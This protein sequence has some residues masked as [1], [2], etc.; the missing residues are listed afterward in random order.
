[1][2]HPPVTLFVCRRGPANGEPRDPIERALSEKA[3]D[4][5][6]RIEAR[7][8]RRL[9]EILAPGRGFMPVGARR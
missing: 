1:M 9:R 2:T 8:R 7:N 5:L 4:A 6:A 3:A